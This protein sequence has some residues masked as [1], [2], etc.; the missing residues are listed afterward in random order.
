MP[1]KTPFDYFV[2]I[3]S[4]VPY[5]LQEVM[6]NSDF[7]GLPTPPSSIPQP[8]YNWLQENL[9]Q[10]L[11]RLKELH[12]LWIEKYAKPIWSTSPI[13]QTL[14]GPVEAPFETVLY[15]SDMFRAW[16][17]CTYTTTLMLT[18]ML[19]EQV[20][21]DLDSSL[22]Y[23]SPVIQSLFPYT[24]LQRLINDMCRC[25][26]YLLLDAHGSRGYIVFMFPAT[27]AY[28]ASDK[29]S[30]EAKWLYDICKRHAGSS[31][32]GF[33]D[34]ALDQV[35]PLSMWMDE[36]KKQYHPAPTP[37]QD[38]MGLSREEETAFNSTTMP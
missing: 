7:S 22:P 24:S 4:D 38:W 10:R 29:G 15:F 28:F 31:G 26:E 37:P 3:L 30:L 2:D 13:A 21:H 18:M 32:F 9:L 8:D 35:M 11:E 17:F 23:P 36:Y 19:Y 16:D 33:G 1:A 20:S 5:F 14:R 34:F 27:V 12:D 25:T 6:R